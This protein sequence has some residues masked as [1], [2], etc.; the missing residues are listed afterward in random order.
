MK[1]LKAQLELTRVL[2]AELSCGPC[3]F[4][5]LEKRVL[6]K[7]GT[8][9]TVTILLYFLRD[10]GFIVKG[11]CENRAPYAISVKGQLLLEALS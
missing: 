3:R 11:A 9:A 7:A 10:S 1:K 8:Y 2:L 4:S 6:A 5:I